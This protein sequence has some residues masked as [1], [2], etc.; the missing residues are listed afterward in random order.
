MNVYDLQQFLRSLGQ[1][2]SV[3]GAKKV[4]EELERACAG[5]EPFRNLSLAQ[6]A[7]FLAK[8]DEYA[9]TGIIPTTGRAKLVTTGSKVGDP[10]A[11]ARAVE[12]IRVL[13]DRVTTPD[14]TYSTIDAEL[15]QL[16]KQY[17]KDEIIEIAKAIGIQGTLKT[18]RAAIDEIK[19]CM[20]ERKESFQRTQF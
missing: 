4:A 20:T 9:R 18:K 6:F 15:K 10:A 16:D 7:D 3:S 17:K 13:Y 2:L 1:P 5:L 12:H 14:V 11:L 19:R 8:A